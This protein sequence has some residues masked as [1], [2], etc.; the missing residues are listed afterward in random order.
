MNVPRYP[1]SSFPGANFDGGDSIPA[2]PEEALRFAESREHALLNVITDF[3]FFVR[4][5]GV[6]LRLQV[7]NQGGAAMREENVVGKR[8]MEL[9]PAQIGQQAQHYIE[10]TFRTGTPQ[11]FFAQHRVA[12]HL[13]DFE[14]RIAACGPDEAVALVRDV[15]ERKLLQKEILEISN[16]EQMRIGQDLHDGLGQ[17]LTGVTF[18]L[19]ALERKLAVRGVPEATEAAQISELVIQALSQTR[20]LARGLF[21]V[22]LESGGLLAGL[23]EL[24]STVEELFKISC[25]VDCDGGIGINN[26]SVALHLFRLVQ[27]A[28]NNS[29]KHGKAKQVVIRFRATGDTLSLSVRDDG[30]GFARQGLNSKGLGLRIMNYRAQKVGA[31]LEIVSA[32]GGGTEVTCVMPKPA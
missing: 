19:K 29:V 3:V 16:R 22:D 7:P 1:G 21:P 5:N 20:N 13:H 32:E 4:K 15:T 17:H 6:V 11:V 14:A 23:R 26:R 8:I 2:S 10:K 9:L 27:E 24:A 31:V 30:A 18:L 12:G 28:I 25:H